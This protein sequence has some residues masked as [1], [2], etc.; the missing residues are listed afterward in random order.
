MENKKP[1]DVAVAPIPTNTS[2]WTRQMSRWWK[3]IGISPYTWGDYMVFYQPGEQTHYVL[4]AGKE[5]KTGLNTLE[6]AMAY[7]EEHSRNE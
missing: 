6:A 2:T 4:L 1:H 3:C 5:I 7:A